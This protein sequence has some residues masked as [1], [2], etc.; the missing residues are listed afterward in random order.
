MS[1]LSRRIALVAAPALALSGLVALPS[2]PSYAAGPT[3]DPAPLAH[4]AAWLAGELDGG[5]L[6]GQYGPTYGTTIDAAL[7]L[8]TI[9]AQPDAVSAISARIETD[10]DDYVTGEAFGDTGSLY[11]GAASKAARLRRV[12]RRDV[13]R[14][15]RSQPPDRRR[16]PGQ[17]HRGRRG[18]H[19]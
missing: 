9:G 4:G 14:L 11:A 10:L 15:R 13:H 7:A 3:T 8:A 12:R 18:A 17:H 5:A 16:E 2:A 1:H 19:R 6:V